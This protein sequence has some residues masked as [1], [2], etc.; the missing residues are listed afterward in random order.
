MALRRTIQMML[1]QVGELGWLVP[2]LVWALVD[3]VLYSCL[4][5]FGVGGEGVSFRLGQ[6]TSKPDCHAHVAQ[7]KT[8]ASAVSSEVATRTLG[9][10]SE[11]ELLQDLFL[12]IKYKK[13][14]SQAFAWRVY[15]RVVRVNT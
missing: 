2:W 4:Y 15:F 1:A 8:T 5:P 7:C 11:W 10:V 6:G 13:D 14:F 9:L 3:S 12:I